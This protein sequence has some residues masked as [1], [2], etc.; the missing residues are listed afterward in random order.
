[1]IAAEFR[2]VEKFF[3]CSSMLLKGCGRQNL[4]CQFGDACN[5]ARYGIEGK[6]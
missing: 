2:G 5:L 6:R 3:L 4:K 1:M